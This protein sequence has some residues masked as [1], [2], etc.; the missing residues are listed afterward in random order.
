L[1][2]AYGAG[3]L[4]ETTLAHR[5]DLL[6]AGRIVDPVHLVG[7]LTRRA[8]RRPWLVSVRGTL[9]VALRGFRNDEDRKLGEP[10]VLL[11]LDWAGGQ[12]ELLVGRH[13]SCDVVLSSTNV[14][15]RHA[16]LFFRDGGWIVRDLDSTNGTQVNGVTVGRCELHPGDRLVIGDH[17]LRID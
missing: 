9:A 12:E 7:D 13:A 3:L 17:H 11:A 4:S 14:S 1:N 2:A 10:P 5:L 8:P 15:R 6:L 16:R